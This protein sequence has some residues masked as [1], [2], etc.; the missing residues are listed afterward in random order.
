MP[1]VKAGVRRHRR[2]KKILKETKGFRGTRSKTYRRAYEAY[3]RAGEH[4][5]LGRKL[6]KRDFRKLWIQRINA[7]LGEHGLKYS[8]FINLLN[9]NDIKINRKVLSE[10]AVKHDK[11][12]ASIVEKVK[13]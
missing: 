9:K 10:L 1:R 2:H 11:V 13:K 8:R 4:S 5:F 6:R 3:L 7:A 12:F